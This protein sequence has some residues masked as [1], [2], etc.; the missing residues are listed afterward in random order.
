MWRWTNP[1]KFRYYQADLVKALF[2]NWTLI[3]V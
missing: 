1:E 2:G 3:T